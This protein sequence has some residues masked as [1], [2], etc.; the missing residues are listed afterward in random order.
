MRIT[1]TLYIALVSAILLAIAVAGI[2]LWNIRPTSK[3]D[4]SRMTEEMEES[5]EP[6][7]DEILVPMTKEISAQSG[8]LDL[9]VLDLVPKPS[10]A[11]V[12]DGQVIYDRKEIPDETTE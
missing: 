4:P 6:T 9:D 3:G 5:E 12:V 2:S 1:K 10:P 7:H 11:Q 8:E